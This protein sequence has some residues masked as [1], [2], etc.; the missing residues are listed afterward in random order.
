MYYIY[1]FRVKKSGM[2]VYVGSTRTI[3]ARLNEHRR[4]MREVERSQPIHK[5][6]AENNLEL[7]KDVEFSVIDCAADKRE[8]LEL[9][10]RYFNIH[11][12]TLANVWKAEK[13]E[14]TN[15]PVRKPLKVVGEEIYFNSQREA[16]EYY[17]VSRQ[18]VNKMV[19][20][21]ELE[22]ID[23][24]D[25]YVNESTGERFISAYQV[26][27]R[28]GIDSKRTSILSKEGRLII[29]GMTISKV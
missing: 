9:E 28:Y 7:L 26:A 24:S 2:V 25:A 15:S 14:A 20:S 18:R 17:G 8:A 16:A 6:L 3:G 29:H 13:R 1:L 21:G 22:E 4:G 11:K 5:Y 27:K 19:K 10:A 12:S 23:I